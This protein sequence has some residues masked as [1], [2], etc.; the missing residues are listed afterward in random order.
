MNSVALYFS[1]SESEEEEQSFR[2]ER[3]MLRDRSNIFQIGEKSKY[4]Y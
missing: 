1:D 2:I 4:Y 3:K